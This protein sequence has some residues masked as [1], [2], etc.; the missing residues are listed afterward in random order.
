MLRP[1]AVIR[2]IGTG[3]HSGRNTGICKRRWNYK[4]SKHE[5]SVTDY[6]GMMSLIFWGG[7]L[8]QDS[9]TDDALLISNK[10]Q[11]FLQLILERV[12]SLL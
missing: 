2:Q 8:G 3:D 7:V 10:S 12:V 4:V 6:G 11:A 1:D 9:E 5:K